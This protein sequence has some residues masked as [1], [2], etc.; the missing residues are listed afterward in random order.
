MGAAGSSCPIG[1]VSGAST[2]QQCWAYLFDT[3]IVG[4]AE[5]E[6]WADVVWSDRDD[7]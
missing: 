2:E 1:S 7:E 3:G 4:K 6:A 5:A